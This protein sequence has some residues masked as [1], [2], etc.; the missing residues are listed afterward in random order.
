[1]KA[2]DLSPLFI[3]CL[4]C[5]VSG[6]NAS[7]PIELNPH[8]VVLKH[9][10]PVSINCST[11]ETDF[12]G[13]GWEATEGGATPEIVNH[14]IWSVQNLTNW[15]VSV[16]CYINPSPVSTFGQCSKK[17][18]IVLYSKSQVLNTYDML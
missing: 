14:R 16:A 15:E 18:N 11:T 6:V 17:A 5:H 1:M 3:K 13:L 4:S 7:C 8:S 9:G 12:D 2:N 10:E